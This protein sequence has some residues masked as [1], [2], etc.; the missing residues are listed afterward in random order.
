[1]LKRVHDHLAIC[2]PGMVSLLVDRKRRVK[3]DAAN[4]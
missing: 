1:M 3:D 4:E 2:G